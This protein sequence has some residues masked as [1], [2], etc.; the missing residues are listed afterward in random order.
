LLSLIPFFNCANPRDDIHLE[1][2]DYEREEEEEGQDEDLD[3]VD[4]R[5]KR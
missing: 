5:K 2:E 3:I 4:I 1:D